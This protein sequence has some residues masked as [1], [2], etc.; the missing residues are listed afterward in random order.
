MSSRPLPSSPSSATDGADHQ[1][2]KRKIQAL[3]HKPPP[4]TTQHNLPLWNSPSVKRNKTFS[5]LKYNITRVC[6]NN[7]TPPARV[8]EMETIQVQA[9]A[10][11][12]APDHE[13]L[14]EAAT[15]ERIEGTAAQILEP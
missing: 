13:A 11:D 8:L 7:P 14:A 1:D 6:N 10:V 4:L 5:F 12:I 9:I 2:R 15:G 3:F